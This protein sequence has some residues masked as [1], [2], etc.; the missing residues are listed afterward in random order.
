MKPVCLCK[1]VLSFSGSLSCAEVMFH[2]KQA[3]L[4]LTIVLVCLAVL[5]SACSHRLASKVLLACYINRTGYLKV[6]IRFQVAS[7]GAQPLFLRGRGLRLA[8]GWAA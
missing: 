1:R 8:L 6:E 2:L 7:F 3:N 4:T 5:L